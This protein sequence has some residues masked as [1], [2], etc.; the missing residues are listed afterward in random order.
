MGE[1]RGARGGEL[2]RTQPTVMGVVNPLDEH[3]WLHLEGRDDG[4]DGVSGSCGA[5]EGAGGGAICLDDVIGVVGEGL[6]GGELWELAD[7]AIALY[8]HCVTVAVFDD[9]FA[10]E[11]A[12]GLV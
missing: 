4:G 1:G 8:D 7:D 11:D 12:D 10:A 2:C 6:A 5:E 3:R 9:P